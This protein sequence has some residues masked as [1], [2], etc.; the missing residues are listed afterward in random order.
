MKVS[1]NVVKMFNK[2]HLLTASLEVAST[3]ILCPN[4]SPPLLLASSP[5][6][7]DSRGKNLYNYMNHMLL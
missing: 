1:Q 4:D 2:L 6:P 5:E 3:T 7:L